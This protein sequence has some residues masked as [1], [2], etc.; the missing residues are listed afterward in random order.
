MLLISLEVVLGEGFFCFPVRNWEG[1]WEGV[2]SKA[3]PEVLD[4]KYR[5]KFKHGFTNRG[6]L[7]CA[8][9]KALHGFQEKRAHRSRDIQFFFSK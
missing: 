2:F 8:I 3:V 5:S 1:V 4:M 7:H 9:L 6:N